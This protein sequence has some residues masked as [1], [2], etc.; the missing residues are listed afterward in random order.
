MEGG[1]DGGGDCMGYLCGVDGGGD[2][3]G[4][5]IEDRCYGHF[6][7]INGRDGIVGAK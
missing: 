5:K 6:C 7:G 3:G 1:I 2:C 4:V